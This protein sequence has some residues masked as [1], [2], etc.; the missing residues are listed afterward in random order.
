MKSV[1][2]HSQNIFPAPLPL[3]WSLFA[4]F[5]IRIESSRGSTY[6]KLRDLKINRSYP[7]ANNIQSVW[8]KVRLIS[9]KEYTTRNVYPSVRWKVRVRA[10]RTRSGQKIRQSVMAFTISPCSR[11][12]AKLSTSRFRQISGGNLGIHTARNKNI[13][14]RRA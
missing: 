3:Y 14:L 13:G 11:R 9:V 1:I 10:R 6:R 12:G 4:L 7:S 2:D 8:Y 5:A